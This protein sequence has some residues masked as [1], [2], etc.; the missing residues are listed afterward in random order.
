MTPEKKKITEEV[1]EQTNEISI[2]VNNDQ[3]GLALIL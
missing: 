1:K 3:H 2:I